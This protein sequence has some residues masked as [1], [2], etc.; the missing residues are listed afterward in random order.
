LTPSGIAGLFSFLNG[1]RCPPGFFFKKDQAL[2][3]KYVEECCE[4]HAGQQVQENF[5]KRDKKKHR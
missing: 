4:I 2:I 1:S 3:A 5:D